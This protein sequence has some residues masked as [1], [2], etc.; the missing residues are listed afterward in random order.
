LDYGTNT[1]RCL[2]VDVSNGREVGTAVWEYAH[3][4]HGVM[5]A[6]DPNLARQHP[7]DYLEG[8]AVTIQQAL[9]QAKIKPA[10]VVGIGVDIDAPCPPIGEGDGKRHFLWTKTARVPSA[11]LG[12]QGHERRS[13]ECCENRDEKE[14]HKP[15]GHNFVDEALPAVAVETRFNNVGNQ[16]GTENATGNNRVDVVGQLVRQGECVRAGAH[17]AKRSRQNDGTDKAQDA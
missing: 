16:D 9:K 8:A 17:N 12:I 14:N 15:E 13:E 5:L 1:V 6:R 4:T 10:Q 11:L 7:G 2:V 3:G